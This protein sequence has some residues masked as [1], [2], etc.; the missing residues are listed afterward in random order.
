MAP[1][2]FGIRALS[3][4]YRLSQKLITLDI[5]HLMIL[6]SESLRT[7]PQLRNDANLSV[8]TPSQVRQFAADPSNELDAALARRIEIGNDMCVAAYCGD[9]M[10]AYAWYAQGSIEASYNQG[11]TVHSGT[12][13]SFPSHMSF[14]YKAFT[15]PDF[16]GQGLYKHVNKY[17]LEQLNH[18]G[19]DT[20]L[21]TTDWSNLPALK[22]CYGLG[23]QHLGNIWR[24]GFP[25]LVSGVYPN[26]AKKMQIRFGSKASTLQRK[27][28]RKEQD[29]SNHHAQ[30]VIRQL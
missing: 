14:L 9:R 7:L 10:A 11:R 26:T 20:I 21:A 22:S 18:E 15:H 8:L 23:F 4:I 16:R 19:I 30:V 3:Y 27:N 13:I 28:V 1:L 5:T 12:A 29:A 6:K 25:G 17:A 24:M 2:S